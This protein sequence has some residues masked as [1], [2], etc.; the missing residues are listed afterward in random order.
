MQ[1]IRYS[2]KKNNQNNFKPTTIFDKK[3]KYI[4][5]LQNTKLCIRMRAFGKQ[6]INSIVIH[7]SDDCKIIVK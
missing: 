3:I 6:M 4:P 7:C 1:I 2:E 5:L